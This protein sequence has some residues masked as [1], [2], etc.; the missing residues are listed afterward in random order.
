MR[1]CPRFAPPGW[2]PIEDGTES[3]TPT[4]TPSP[5][6]TPTPAPTD[7]D[8][9]K[10]VEDL[11]KKHGND[12]N[13][14]LRAVLADRDEWKSKHDAVTARLP[15]EGAVVLDGDAAK[16]W[17]TYQGLGKPEDL[18]QAVYERDELR[19]QAATRARADLHGEAAKLT[20]FVPA[21]LSRLA[22]QDELEIVLQ[23]GKDRAGKAVKVPHVKTTDDKGAEILTALDKHAETHWKEF[24][25]SLRAS[26]QPPSHRGSPA[27][28]G[29]SPRP[30]I[31]PGNQSRR[32]LV[33]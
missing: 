33:R 32:S 18:Q 23:D 12:G 16:L 30:D 20:G 4:P 13:A 31:K 3:P 19:T 26:Q 15:K 27:P 2:L 5:T 24:L 21:V 14:A 28:A 10:L 8:H 29:G 6:P 1:L 9:A 17:G 22:D 7:V 11:L 25:P